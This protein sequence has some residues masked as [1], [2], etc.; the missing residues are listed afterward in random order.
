MTTDTDPN[1]RDEEADLL[2][3]FAQTRDRRLRNEIVE[4]YMGFATHIAQR[5]VRS[6]AATD[7]VR[8]AAM[9]GLVKAVDRFDPDHGATFAAFAGVTIEGELKRYLRDQTWVVRVPRSAKELHLAVARASGDLEQSLGRTPTV[10]ELAV[11][12]QVDRDDVL[13]GIAA[14]AA[15]AVGSLEAPPRQARPTG[16]RAND[17]APDNGVAE[18]T[19]RLLVEQLMATL[20]EREREIVRLR[21]FEELSQAQIA[22]RMG[23]SQMHVSRLLRKA[24]D[25]LRDGLELD[26]QDAEPGTSPS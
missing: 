6:R 13:R 8:Q 22:S 19:D 10:D 18:S 7:D 25:Q 24:F 16:S 2:L 9:I 26:G 14:G 15:F 12:L 5:Y 23:M 21:F 3:R 17:V 11:H 4:R 1:A 20:P